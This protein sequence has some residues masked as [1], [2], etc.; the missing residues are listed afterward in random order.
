MKEREDLQEVYDIML[1]EFDVEPDQLEADMHS[2]L[3]QL[4]ESGLVDIEDEEK[5]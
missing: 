2:F 3:D 5:D 4:A 1:E